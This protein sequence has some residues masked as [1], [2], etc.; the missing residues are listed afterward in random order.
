M[1]LIR[2]NNRNGNKWDPFSELEKFHEEFNRA[3]DFSPARWGRMNLLDS[4]LSPA[5]DIYDSKDAVLVRA[6][7]P[8]M[9][10]DEIEVS[11]EQGTLLI[12]G[13]K[14]GEEKFED[15]KTVREERFYGS[16]TRAISLPQGIDHEKVKATYENGVLELSFPKK[17]EAK[18]KQIK[19]QVK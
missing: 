18:P 3:F 6:N 7:I 12:K 15:K 10:K 8:G 11:I 17:E 14:K 19:V 16:F 4:E 2:K 5:V 13:E 1:N 9:K